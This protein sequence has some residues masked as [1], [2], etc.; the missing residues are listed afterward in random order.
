MILPDTYVV[1][2]ALAILAAVCWGSWLNSYKLT[3]KRR[4][5]F[6]YW[7]YAFGVLAGAAL[8]AF[9]FGSMGFQFGGDVS[10]FAFMDDLMRS[11][12]H[13]LA[14]GLGAGMV[15]NL[16]NILLVASAS[17]TGMSLAFPV[18]LGLAAVVGLSTDY[19][20]KPHANPVLVFAAC[21]LVTVAVAVDVVAHRM[22][23]LARAKETIKTGKTRSTRVMASW[24]G[25]VLALIGGP[26]VGLC[27]PLEE[28]SR[29]PDIG[30]GPYAAAFMFAL[31]VLLSTFVFNLFFMNL[32]VQGQPVEL[33]EYFRQP[34]KLHL[35]GWV[36]GLVWSAGTVSCLVAVSAE[37]SA[38]PNA[39]PS[40]LL[41]PVTPHA[42]VLGALLLTALYGLAPWKE[43]RGAT[44]RVRALA[45]VMVTLFAAALGLILLVHPFGR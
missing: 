5:E 12:K 40:P 33:R 8:G 38:A 44:L 37:A 7:D 25:I 42:V 27:Y 35:L 45:I 1:A 43:L 20:V 23:S 4:F 26:I 34:K 32:P 21:A 3:G 6:F 19:I 29:A 18:G 15:F 31:G 41:G 28:A 13:A 22:L 2:L 17:L 10:G 39:E 16:G 14:Y 24:K 36:G 9:T 11:S 30:M